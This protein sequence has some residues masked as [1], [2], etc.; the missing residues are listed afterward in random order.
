MARENELD[1]SK[2]KKAHS[3]VSV[4]AEIQGN[5]FKQDQDYNRVSVENETT[6]EFSPDLFETQKFDGGLNSEKD[7][8][9]DESELNREGFQ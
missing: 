1:Q 9:T 8:S 6:K 3:P 2:E 5:F 4:P 7:I